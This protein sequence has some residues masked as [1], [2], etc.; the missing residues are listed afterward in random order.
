MEKLLNAEHLSNRYADERHRM[1]KLRS[2]V[3]WKTN[4]S[5]NLEGTDSVPSFGETWPKKLFLFT[6]RK[7]YR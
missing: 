7:I 5:M 4:D 1:V 6:V 3:T 2:C